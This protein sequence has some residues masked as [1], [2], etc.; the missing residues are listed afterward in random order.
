M[1]YYLHYKA[2]RQR[3]TIQSWKSAQHVINWAKHNPSVIDQN[4]KINMASVIVR[5]RS[6]WAVTQ[7]LLFFFFLLLWTQRLWGEKT[8]K[9]NIITNIR[10]VFKIWME[11]LCS[12]S[13]PEV[14]FRWISPDVEFPPLRG[15]SIPLLRLLQPSWDWLTDM[16]NKGYS[17]C[18]L[19]SLV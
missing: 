9:T 14:W 17:I 2:F 1:Q 12:Q 13:W 3:K 8:T 10:T 19:R 16:D 4:T 7:W 18:V 11:I 15:F 5:S 6:I